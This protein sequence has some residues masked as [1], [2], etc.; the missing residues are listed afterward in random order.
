LLAAPITPIRSSSPID[1]CF[2]RIG[3]VEKY[4][5]VTMLYSDIKGFTKYSSTSTPEKVSDEL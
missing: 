4:E 3:I 5:G 1:H 2:S